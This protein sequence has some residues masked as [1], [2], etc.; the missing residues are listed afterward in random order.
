MNSKIITKDEVKLW[1]VSL[2]INTPL[3]S[4]YL[5]DRLVVK[6]AYEKYKAGDVYFNNIR[7]LLDYIRDN[8]NREIQLSDLKA[9]Y[10]DWRGI[11]FDSTRKEECRDIWDEKAEYGLT[12]E[13]KQ[14]QHDNAELNKKINSKLNGK[15]K[16]DA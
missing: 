15:I 8:I 7:E 11:I 12:E 14:V 13:E 3:D 1:I 4:W 5:S 10:F 16:K 2:G 9:I 6:E